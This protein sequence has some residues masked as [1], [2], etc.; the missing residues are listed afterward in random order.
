MQKAAAELAITS[1]DGHNCSAFASAK[2]ELLDA[3]NYIR[4]SKNGRAKIGK[5]LVTCSEFAKHVQTKDERP[6]SALLP[7]RIDC[8]IET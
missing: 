7:A 6:P 5:K 3:S 4:R 1:F 8:Y 2:T